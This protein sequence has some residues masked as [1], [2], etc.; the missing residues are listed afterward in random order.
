[1]VNFFVRWKF[2]VYKIPSQ[3]CSGIS[4]YDKIAGNILSDPPK[5][6]TCRC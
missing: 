1:M 5:S 3:S 4:V 6:L 2:I